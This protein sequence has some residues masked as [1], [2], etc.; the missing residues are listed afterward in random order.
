MTPLRFVLAIPSD[1][2]SPAFPARVPHPEEVRAARPSIWLD[3]ATP[4]VTLEPAGSLIGCA[5]TRK[6]GQLVDTISLGAGESVATLAARLVRQYWGAYVAILPDP[7][8]RGF[9]VMSDPS[10][11]C[12]VYRLETSRHLLLAS[13]AR[14]LGAAAGIPIGVDF[15]ALDAFLRFPELRQH[16]TCLQG[17]GELTPGMLLH[18]GGREPLEVS[19][20]NLADHLPRGDW[21]AFAEAAEELRALAIRTIRAWAERLGPVAVATSG[22]VDSS[23]LCAALAGAGRDFACITLATADRSGDESDYAR[24]LAS[25]L[26]AG[27]ARRVYDPALYDPAATASAG[28]PR[29][30]RKGFVS[31]VD[32]LLADGA[33]ELGASA[34]FDGN[35][36]DNLFCF[37][38][39]A[40]PIVDRLRNDGVRAAL[41]ETLPDMCRLTGCDIP[42]MLRATGK[43]LLAR[44]HDRGWE[45]DRR[46]L[47]GSDQELRPE[48]LTA[49]HRLE[50][51]LHEGKRDHLALIMR[52]QNHVHG[53]GP[54]PARF[55]PL[56]SQPL[57][58]FCLGVPTWFWIRGG[59]N[60]ALARAAFQDIL[61]GSILRRSSKAGPD[62]FLRGAFERH[63]DAL[64]GRLSGGVLAEAGLIDRAALDEAF[65]LETSR[66]GSLV[67]RLLDLV[68]A[69]NWA[70]SWS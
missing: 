66:R 48:P 26:D 9:G 17:I 27:F 38:H 65:T 41:A 35:G 13:D 52:A 47:V 33:R 54:G 30:A 61:P 11:L 45:P 59:Q 23:F 43:R 50:P 42:T 6:T 20:W 31:V 2:A 57:L 8:G 3:D 56:M 58:E 18:A 15:A 36:G 4:E 69:E 46:L 5:F 37:L 7:E 64:H 10:G 29:P 62:S 60:R 28:L 53:A 24:L 1:C 49:W 68:E 14:L 12:P 19:A 40:A 39:S 55:S 32:A 25:H 70:R 51:G 67:Y 44:R 21:P 16:R 34:V 22:G 63:R